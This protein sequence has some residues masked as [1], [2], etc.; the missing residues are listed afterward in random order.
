[1]MLN[2]MIQNLLPG[3]I[4]MIL[5]LAIPQAIAG[6]KLRVLV[7]D[8]ELIDE[9]KQNPNEPDKPANLLRVERM[10]DQIRHGL[11]SSDYYEVIDI[12]L[13]HDAIEEYRSGRYLHTCTNCMIRIG[14]AVDAD[15][16][17]ASWT[18]VVSSLIQNQ[19]MVF[20]DV[21]KGDA[22]MTAFTDSRSNS[23]PAWRTA[24]RALLER[25]YNK[26]HD[27][28]VPEGLREYRPAS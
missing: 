2:K 18:Q 20:Y 28:N 5:V 11:N 7:L 21:E 3:I 10:G 24:T 17:V 19:N 26:Y 27:G 15:L 23:D 4:G 22:V 14:A 16:V 25:F 13:A 9:M 1:M 8:T 6:E 12:E